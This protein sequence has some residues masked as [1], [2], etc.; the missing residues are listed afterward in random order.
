[1]GYVC[2]VCDAPQPDAEHLANHLAFTAM[3]RHD[4]HE[5]WL[6]DH[7]PDWG[8]E[9]P[10]SLGDR[11]AEQLPETAVDGPTD[12]DTR[13]R[14]ARRPPRDAPGH[15]PT[16][17]PDATR[18]LD[19]ADRAVLREARELTRQMVDAAEATDADADA[20]PATSDDGKD[21]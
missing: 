3:L 10:A 17:S 9:S 5:S 20:D 11:L 4:E 21:S 13:E 1:M 14:R 6:D 18:S 19:A 2:P 16:R 7:A 12:E 8:S 15:D